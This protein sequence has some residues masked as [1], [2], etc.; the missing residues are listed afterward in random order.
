[1]DWFDFAI[2]AGFPLAAL[3]FI[4]W[5][6]VKYVWPFIVKAWNDSQ[7]ERREE[8]EKSLATLEKTQG[9]FERLID[10]ERNVRIEERDK[11]LAAL[12]QQS[13]TLMRIADTQAQIAETQDQQ[14]EKM[15][16]ITESQVKITQTQRQILGTLPKTP[17]RNAPRNDK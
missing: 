17:K 4:G 8:R 6:L 12:S 13:A 10:I 2:R 1:M 5:F 11:F 3:A 9:M 7:A 15:A 16:Q 14:G